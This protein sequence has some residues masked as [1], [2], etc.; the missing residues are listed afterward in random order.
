MFEFRAWLHKGF[1]DM[2]KSK[3]HIESPAVQIENMQHFPATSQ[4]LS[5]VADTACQMNSGVESQAVVFF[6]F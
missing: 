4:P 5:P 3:L 1:H 6:Q 2:G